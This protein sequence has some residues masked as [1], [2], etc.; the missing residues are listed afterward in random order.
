MYILITILSCLTKNFVFKLELLVIMGPF[1]RFR[2][3]YYFFFGKA[4]RGNDWSYKQERN[5]GMA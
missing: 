3:P 5:I 4:E 2:Y 1:F